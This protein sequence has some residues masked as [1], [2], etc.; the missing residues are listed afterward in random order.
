MTERRF[1]FRV[2]LSAG[3][4]A[5]IFEWVDRVF[6]AHVFTIFVPLQ[7]ALLKESIYRPITETTHS[8]LTGLA[9]NRIR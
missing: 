2:R 8:A 3:A 4:P 9:R 6:K 1:H 7:V 5:L